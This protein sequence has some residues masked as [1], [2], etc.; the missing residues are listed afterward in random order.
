MIKVASDWAAPIAIVPEA[1]VSVTVDE[2][3]LKAEDEP[4]VSHE[5]DAEIE[6]VVR[7]MEFV[8]ASFMVT[9]ETRIEDGGPIRLPPRESARLAPPGL[10]FPAVVRRAGT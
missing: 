2:P 8:P 4:E 7:E 6:P 5:P 10:L 3:A 9:P 1:A